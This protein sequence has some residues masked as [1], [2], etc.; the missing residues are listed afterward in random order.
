MWI[1]TVRAHWR[2]AVP[3]PDDGRQIY[4]YEC[5]KPND[6]SRKLR[7]PMRNANSNTLQIAFLPRSG[8]TPVGK[9]RSYASVTANGPMTATSRQNTT[10]TAQELK[11]RHENREQTISVY[12][13]RVKQKLEK[14]N[15]ASVDKYKNDIQSRLSIFS[16]I[17][18]SHLSE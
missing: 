8:R 3:P 9:L 14:I 18:K 15:Y 12:R 7:R 4:H 16:N 13:H 2:Q 17:N 11:G 5:D 6:S 10:A 1:L